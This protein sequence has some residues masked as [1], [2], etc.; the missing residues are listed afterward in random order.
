MTIAHGEGNYFC[1]P[2]T[3]AELEDNDQIVF[4]YTDTKGRANAEANP[5]GSIEN[6]A[7]IC[8]RQGNVVGLMPHPE[9]SCDPLLGGEDGLSVFKSVM[10]VAVSS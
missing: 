7:G 9:R 4:R 10:Q 5:N 8:N 1:E 3:L 2:G 6:I